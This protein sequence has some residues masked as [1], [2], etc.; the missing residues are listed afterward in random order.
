M[1][2]SL[3]IRPQPHYRRDAFVKGLERIGYQMHANGQPKDERDV[4]VLWNRQ[5]GDEAI[6]AQWESHGGT[7]VVTENGY[8]GRDDLNRQHYAIA[9]HGHCGSG[10]FPVGPEDRMKPLAIELKPWRQGGGHVLVCGQRGIGSAQMRSPIGW[11]DRAA[12]RLKAAGFKN[13]RIR[14]HPGRQ[15]PVTPLKDD[16]YDA[17]VCVVWS[18]SCGVKAMA[19]GIPVIY[20]APKWILSSAAAHGLEHAGDP[21]RDDEKRYSAFATMMHAQWSVAEIE[22]GEPFRRILARIGEA[23]W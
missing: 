6:A 4:L 15:P 23:R 17:A 1:I 16:L 13:L 11:E 7:V 21:L 14:R 19:Q 12:M 5:G 9:V 2:A 3:H 20:A 8:L 18:S 10:W 22:A